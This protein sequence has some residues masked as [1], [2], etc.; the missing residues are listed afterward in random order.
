VNHG[1]FVRAIVVENKMD[2]QLGRNARMDDLKEFLEFGSSMASIAFPDI[3]VNVIMTQYTGSSIT[4]PR[5]EWYR[6]GGLGAI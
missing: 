3:T 2:I 1:R 6:D 5:T 4:E